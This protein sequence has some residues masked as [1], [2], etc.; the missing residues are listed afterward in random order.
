MKLN[1][2]RN[3]IIA[4]L[5]ILIGGAVTFVGARWE[6]LYQPSFKGGTSGAESRYVI[7][8]DSVTAGTS[9][10]VFGD[11]TFNGGYVP[12]QSIELTDVKIYSTEMN[13]GD[14]VYVNVW[15]VNEDDTSS[16]I[17]LA[18]SDSLY[19]TGGDSLNMWIQDQTMGST[20]KTVK[21]FTQT[22]TTGEE[23]LAIEYKVVGSPA[24]VTIVIETKSRFNDAFE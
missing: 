17:I 14:T 4:L 5:T 19:L 1:I 13:T 10:W 7:N 6:K 3:I 20:T 11:T 12:E 22:L 2:S 24:G 8:I 23:K 9:H 16:E 15:A 18:P 21:Q